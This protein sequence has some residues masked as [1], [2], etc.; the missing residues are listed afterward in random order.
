MDKPVS[1]SATYLCVWDL[2]LGFI[3]FKARCEGLKV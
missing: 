2:G 1:V 3:A